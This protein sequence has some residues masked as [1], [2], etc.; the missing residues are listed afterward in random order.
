MR[1]FV[2]PEH[3]KKVLQNNLSNSDKIHLIKD[4]YQKIKSNNPVI[5]IVIPAYNEEENI[6]QTLLTISNNIVSKPIEIIVVNN[7]STDNTEALVKA[8]GI[9]CITE[10]KKGIT[11]ARNAGLQTASGT[12]IL[13]ADADTFYSPNWIEYMS[14]PLLNNNLIALTYGRFSFV[15]IDKTPRW[16]Y[17]FYEYFSDITRWLNKHLKDEAVNVYGFSSGYRRAQ[18]LAVDGYNHPPGSNEDGYLA[19]KL[20]NKGFGSLYKVTNINAVAWTT[21]R[22]IQSDGGLFVATFKRVKKFLFK[23]KELIIRNDL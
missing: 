11:A 7:N 1:S 6:L 16:V 18:G 15:P 21:D 5:S 10:T 12:I 3:I 19:L 20:R 4:A 9:S 22:R 14:E 2:V 13:N 17:F 23:P 8:T